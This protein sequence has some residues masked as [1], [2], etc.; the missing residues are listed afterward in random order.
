MAMGL[1]GFFSVGCV[2]FAG[3]CTSWRL[4]RVFAEKGV[5]IRCFGVVGEELAVNP[6]LAVETGPGGVGGRWN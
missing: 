2:L 3:I 4:F 5:E 6:V 1:E